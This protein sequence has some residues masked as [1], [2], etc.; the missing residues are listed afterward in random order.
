MAKS[1]NFVRLKNQDFSLNS[2]NIG[3]I[4]WFL[5]FEARLVST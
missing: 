5:I 4:L 2:N 1:K 3:I